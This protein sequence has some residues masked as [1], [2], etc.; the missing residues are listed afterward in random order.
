MSREDSQC[1]DLRKVM[2]SSM[3]NFWSAVT[4]FVRAM[5]IRFP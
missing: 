1:P 2:R 4:N 5:S 3:L